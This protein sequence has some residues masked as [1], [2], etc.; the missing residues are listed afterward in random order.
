MWPKAANFNL[1]SSYRFER[2]EIRLS[3]WDFSLLERGKRSWAAVGQEKTVG[4]ESWLLL[5]HFCYC[6]LSELLIDIRQIFKDNQGTSL[7]GTDLIGF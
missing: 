6:W 3:K 1:F 2:Q 5:E 7:I 4:E